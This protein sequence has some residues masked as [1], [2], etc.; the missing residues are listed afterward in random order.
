MVKS[1]LFTLSYLFYQYFL[2][3]MKVPRVE[4][5][6]RVFSFKIQFG[7]QVW[8]YP[9]FKQIRCFNISRLLNYIF[10]TGI[11]VSLLQISEF[12]KSL[13]TVNSACDEVV[14]TENKILP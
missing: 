7:S 6:M 1:H 12:K 2:E 13:N 5:K 3:L 10:N 8:W 9:Q 11:S 14:T 4:S